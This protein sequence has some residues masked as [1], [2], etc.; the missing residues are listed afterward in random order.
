MTSARFIWTK[1]ALDKWAAGKADPAHTIS[2]PNIAAV[3]DG[4]VR[5][6]RAG[7]PWALVS[8]A[9]EVLASGGFWRH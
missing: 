7:T 1:G 4:Y 5:Q 6:L 3:Y 2:A 9:D 8:A